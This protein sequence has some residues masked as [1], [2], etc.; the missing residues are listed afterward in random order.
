MCVRRITS[1]GG[2]IAIVERI[3][4]LAAFGLANEGKAFA[5]AH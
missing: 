5:H 2:T 4:L 1:D 3:R